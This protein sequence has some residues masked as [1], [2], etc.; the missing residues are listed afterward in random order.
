MNKIKIQNF[1]IS[2]GILVITIVI[3]LA[4]PCFG[5]SGGPNGGKL[6]G[7]ISTLICFEPTHIAL[8]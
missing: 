5:C 7:M 3:T 1:P 2:G 4:L 8:P 6:R